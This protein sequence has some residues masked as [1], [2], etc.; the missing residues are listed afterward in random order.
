MLF[1]FQ[2]QVAH[3]TGMDV[4]NASM[5]D[6]STATAEAVLM[7]RRADPPQP[8]RP[9]GRPPPALSRRGPHLSRRWPGP[10]LPARLA[11][12]AGRY[13]QPDRQRH[14]RHR[15]ADAGLLRPP[16]QHQG[17]RRC[18]PRRR[19][20]ADRRRHRN[21]LARPDRGPRCARRRYRRRRRPVDRQCAQLRRPLCRPHGH[22]QGVSCARCPAAS[23]AKPSMPTAIAA[24]C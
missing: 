14:R 11:R 13:P 1:E 19:R 24:S 4:A 5:Y 20:A 16:A 15:R 2:T 6:G 23:A 21:R 22:P 8:H 17:C 10:R 3:L 18:R 12:R 9:L 7:A